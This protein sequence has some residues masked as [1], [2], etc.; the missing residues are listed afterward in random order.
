M[1]DNLTIA[2]AVVDRITLKSE[3]GDE[4]ERVIMS[5]AKSDEVEERSMIIPTE[6]YP[7]IGICF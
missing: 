6:G 3:Q 7:P 2:D 4:N 1:T 5:P